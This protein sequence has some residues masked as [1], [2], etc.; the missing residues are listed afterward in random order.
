MSFSIWSGVSQSCCRPSSL[1]VAIFS[2]GFTV[3]F[4]E[5][6][7]FSCLSCLGLEVQ[8]RLVCFLGFCDEVAG[9]RRDDICFYRC[10]VRC[11]VNNPTRPNSNR[12]VLTWICFLV[13]LLPRGSFLFFF[14][15]SLDG[16]ALVSWLS[17]DF[18]LSFFCS[19]SFSY[20]FS[21]YLF[22][23]S[24][25]LTPSF[26]VAFLVF[27]GLQV[28]LDMPECVAWLVAAAGSFLPKAVLL[29]CLWCRI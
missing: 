13:Y 11:L 7:S 4:P 16:K 18:H 29:S 17:M 24:F 2:S 23:L 26:G 8:V 6:S 12:P 27:R 21:L 15:R 3:L 22:F 10:L 5:F 1:D 20:L 9:H 14:W 19:L 28:L 25:S